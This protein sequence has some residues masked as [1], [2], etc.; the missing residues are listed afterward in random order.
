MSSREGSTSN[1]DEVA[2]AGLVA[3]A[4]RLA[5]F[6]VP[7]H[8]RV[9]G[10]VLFGSVADGSNDKE[11]DRDILILL[12]DGEVH[13]QLAALN[14][15]D[16]DVLYVSKAQA[17]SSASQIQKSITIPFCEPWLLVAY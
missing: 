5:A 11:S 2:S 13:K 9:I 6:L 8:T 16:C 7:L 1:I 4:A 17:V 12:A 14:G 3:F 10:A 15:Y